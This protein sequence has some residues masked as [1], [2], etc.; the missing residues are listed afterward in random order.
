[1]LPL[2]IVRIMKGSDD[3]KQCVQLGLDF[4]LLKM[5]V[6]CLVSGNRQS[7]LSKVAAWVGAGCA[8]VFMARSEKS[9]PQAEPRITRV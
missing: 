3:E 1:M 6:F 9:S 7:F 4:M 8:E 2:D 5:L